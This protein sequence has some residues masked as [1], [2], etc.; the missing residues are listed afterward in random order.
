MAQY[1]IEHEHAQTIAVDGFELTVF[2][3]CTSTEA[4]GIWIGGEDEV[5]IV[6]VGQS[7]RLL[8]RARV[9]WIGADHRGEVA[10][11]GIALRLDGVRGDSLAS[12]HRQHRRVAHAM[13]GC[14][15]DGQTRRRERFT[16][17]PLGKHVL[18]IRRIAKRPRLL[19]VDAGNARELPCE[20]GII[21]VVG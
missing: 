13:Q 2:V 4:I 8:H 7:D 11:V 6:S 16:H 18:V 21:A 10:A 5:G 19:G 1:V 9:F 3:A 20:F 14:K 17:H 15:R 12:Q